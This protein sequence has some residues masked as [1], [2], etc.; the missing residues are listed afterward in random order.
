[1]RIALWI[2]AA[3]L[4]TTFPAF[5]YD[6]LEQLLDDQQAKQLDAL[7]EYV[8]AHPDAEDREEAEDR[9][10][11]GYVM[12]SKYDDAL[13]LLLKKYDAA[14][15]NIADLP[16]EQLFGSMIV[17]IVQTYVQAGKITEGKDFV[18][19]VKKDL[20]DKAESEDVAAALT[21]LGEGLKLPSVG[22]TVD[23]KFTALD[24]TEIDVSKMTDKVV[25]V[26]YWATW[27]MP[28]MQELPRVKTIYEK[29]HAKGFEIVG[30]SL[31]EDKEALEKTI[32]D[33]KI[34]WPQAF[35]GD[36][37]DTALAKQY[38]IQSIP[39][40]FLIGKDGKIAGLNMRGDTLE[41]KVAEL[42]GEGAAAAE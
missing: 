14:A 36:A 35:D 38:G 39:T 22:E 21:Q 37:W 12:L 11:Y 26:D 2:T 9:L 27:C 1:M 15:K 13:E 23:I 25:L 40:T 6:S 5:A 18:A 29:Y 30:I 10:A 28:C 34:T 7:K 33:R 20:G 17:P 24:G 8:A 4:A 19:R 41:K 31:D 42:L 3:A 16:M 32:K